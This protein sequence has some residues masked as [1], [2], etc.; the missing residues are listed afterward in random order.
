MPP[1]SS[2]CVAD[3]TISEPLGQHYIC[4]HVNWIPIHNVHADGSPLAA[5]FMKQSLGLLLRTTNPQQ[6]LSLVAT[7]LEPLVASE[8]LALAAIIENALVR[9]ATEEAQQQAFQTEL[10]VRTIA[11][12]VRFC[13][14]PSPN[15]IF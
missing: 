14:I 4:S 3:P 9:G 5:F 12:Q 8:P 15:G 11:M 2:T 6:I 7:V 10:K 13:V 1:S